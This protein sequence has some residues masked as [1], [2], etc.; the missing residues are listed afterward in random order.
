MGLIRVGGDSRSKIHLNGLKK[1]DKGVYAIVEVL[2]S[3]YYQRESKNNFK[4]N[5]E[6][7]ESGRLVVPIKYIRN[8]I[9]NPIR[10]SD[11]GNDMIIKSDLYLLKGVQAAS[12]PLSEDAFNRILLYGESRTS[13]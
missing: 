13:S 1:L 6:K 12:M 7:D 4:I 9:R 3:P 5:Q 8:Y 2:G 11:L 10:F